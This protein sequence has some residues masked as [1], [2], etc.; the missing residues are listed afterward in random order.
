[1]LFLRG[2]RA[3]AQSLLSYLA[4]R[5]MSN[6]RK[7]RSW[8]LRL[9]AVIFVVACF[10][11]GGLLSAV[12]PDVF[13]SGDG[14]LKYLVA[15]QINSG[16]SSVELYPEGAEWVQQIW[17][18]GFYPFKPPFVYDQDDSKIV[19]FPPFF[20][21]LTAPL[22][23]LFGNA[24]LY[25]IPVV[26]LLLLW[27]WFGWI[28]YRLNLQQRVI[29][30]ALFCLFFCSPLTLYAAIY[31]EH[32]LA[33]LLGF[34]GIVF[35]VKPARSCTQAF[36]LGCLTGL[37]VWLRPEALLLWLLIIAVVLYNQAQQPEKRNAYFTAASFVLVALFFVCNK[38][39]YGDFLGAHSYQLITHTPW[40]EQLA[41]SFILF[42]H[43]NAKQF[44]FFPLSL[45]I[46]AMTC[47]AFIKKY[48]VPKECFQLLFISISFSLIAPFLL[49]NGGGKQWGPR[50]FLLLIPSILIAGSLLINTV[51][52]KTATLLWLLVPVVVYSLYLNS[53]SA[54]KTLYDDYA[55]RVKPCLQL[56]QQDKCTILIVQNQFIAQEFA[57]LFETRQIFLAEN[58]QQYTQLETLLRA[59]GK[60]EWIFIARDKPL[61]LPAN[62]DPVRR[63]GDYFFIK[64]GQ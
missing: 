25:I 19:S 60:Q 56:L 11:L 5:C 3:K 43:L 20:Q 47:Y 28:L 46:Y 63:A 57:A 24:G 4:K 14:G 51:R 59:A 37:S 8:F 12:Q 54:C 34:G 44:L 30:G 33:V 45:L 38:A 29:A 41:R 9:P 58:K 23:K 49:P 40:Q 16:N 26:S 27:S 7:E 2:Q 17:A 18:K 21:W 62:A 52:F 53:F 10:F 55:Y 61:L 36:I 22:L 48:A 50:Y 64:C 15:R 13:F 32:T 6:T 31:W 39:L 35:L 1:M 42:T